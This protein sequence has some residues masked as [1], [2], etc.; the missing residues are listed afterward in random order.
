MKKKSVPL[1]YPLEFE[2]N[3]DFHSVSYDIELSYEKKD[4]IKDWTYDYL[5]IENHYNY[6]SNTNMYLDEFH[7]D[8][9][10]DNKDIDYIHNNHNY[11]SKY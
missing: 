10:I 1:V 6:N 11:Y 9:S 8:L 4:I 2:S 5:S 7:N 3:N